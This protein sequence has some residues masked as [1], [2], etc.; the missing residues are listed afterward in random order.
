MGIQRNFAEGT[1]AWKS[2]EKQAFL[3]YFSRLIV[4]LHRNQM[5]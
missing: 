4:S 1:F 5:I 2:K 3:W